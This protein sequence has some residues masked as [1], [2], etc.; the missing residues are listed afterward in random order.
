MPSLRMVSTSALFVECTL[1]LPVWLPVKGRFLLFVIPV[2]GLVLAPEKGIEPLITASVLYSGNEKG[3][4][5]LLSL[6]VSKELVIW[7]FLIL[8]LL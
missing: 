4:V 7:E 2:L 6:Y 5:S 1:A 8:F 3:R